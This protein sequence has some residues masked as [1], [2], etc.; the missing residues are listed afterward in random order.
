VGQELTAASGEFDMIEH[1]ACDVLDTPI[2]P[3]WIACSAQGVC[4]LV[5]P[6]EGSEAALG[7]WLASHAPRHERLPTN[8]FLEQARVELR[9]YFAGRRQTFTVPLDLR[10]PTLQRRVWRALTDIPYG[11]TVSYGSLARRLGDP[12][13]AR[14]VGA[15]CGANPVPIIAP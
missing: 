10:G 1:I 9:D 5:F 14:A 4:K 6:Q 8:P 2:G 13:A 3:L 12:K 11:Q 7:R 15:A